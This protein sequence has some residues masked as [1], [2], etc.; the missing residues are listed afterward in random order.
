VA[1]GLIRLIG[2]RV[3]TLEVRFRPKGALASISMRLGMPFPG[4][5]IQVSVLEPMS[6]PVAR[7]EV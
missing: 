6:V 5:R 4:A 3:L 1:F 2:A 7:R